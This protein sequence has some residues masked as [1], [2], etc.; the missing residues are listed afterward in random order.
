[1]Q[2]DLEK[3]S[4]PLQNGA[5]ENLRYEPIYDK[6]REAR[7]E[8]DSS[9]SRGVW[10]RDLKKADWGQVYALCTEVLE[11]RTKDLQ[12]VGWL[13]ESMCHLENWIGLQKSFEL[14]NNFCEKCWDCFYP[15]KEA[16][17]E[18]RVRLLDWFT[19]KMAELSL[20]MPI[21]EPN[22]LISQPIYLSMWLSAQNFDL[23]SRRSGVN[24]AKVQEAESSGQI[25]L[26]RFRTLIKQASV[27][28]VQAVLQIAGNIAD[29]SAALSRFLTDKLGGHSPSF[30][31]LN[32]RLKNVDQ[33]CKFSL[34]GRSPPQRSNELS[35]SAERSTIET[36]GRSVEGDGFTGN[37]NTPVQG[38]ELL[39]A[40][41]L[42]ADV[43]IDALQNSGD[44]VEP[45]S[46]AEPSQSK[47]A[48]DEVTIATKL[49]AYKAVG[50]LADYLMEV[51]PQSPGPYIIK[52]V[53]SWGDKL[54]PAIL[55]DVV[56]GTT[57]GHKVLKMLSDVMRRGTS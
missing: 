2:W 38:Q 53:S 54:L 50:D 11:E 1:M 5:G 39:D 41:E 40:P 49:D 15:E 20:F 13:C 46:S 19:D 47:P 21:A 22:G 48:D 6:I 30:K 57:A 26:K 32:E 36:T 35:S 51:D 34:D 4:S 8:E 23:V 45:P 7:S 16:D 37:R 25:T 14:A 31:L 55:D 12:L 56:G 10:A 52:M 33:L 18:Y 28:D 42:E 44:S 43:R 29:Q 24:P 27:D 9:L 3:L 17:V